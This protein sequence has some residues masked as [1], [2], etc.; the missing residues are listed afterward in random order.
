[1]P[2]KGGDQEPKINNH[3]K[4]ETG[5]SG[6]MRDLWNKGIP[7]RQIVSLQAVKKGQ[8][9]GPFS[10]DVFVFQCCLSTITLKNW[11]SA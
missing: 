9:S 7:N 8:L 6:C 11:R 4:Q 3:E 10:F 2:E 1:V 5:Y